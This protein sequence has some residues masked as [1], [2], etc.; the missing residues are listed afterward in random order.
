VT[1]TDDTTPGDG[2]PDDD[3]EGGGGEFRVRPARPADTERMAAAHAAATV[4]LG[5]AAY[6]DRQ[7]RAWARG[8]YEYGLDDPGERVVVAV[9]RAGEDDPYDE[10]LG[11]GAVGFDGGDYLASDVDGDLRAVYVHPA[12][13]RQGV[14][15]ALADEIERA[16][17]ERG[18]ASLGLW[19]SRNAVGFYEAR[20]YE[21][22]E[23]HDHEF[24]DDVTATVVEMRRDLDEA[25]P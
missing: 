10:V 14:G 15:T 5:R 9:R 2:D 3:T 12:F 4:A 11:F 16:A 22:V 13:A 23:E 7:V 19:A 8:R 20:G 25:T 24:A 1:V 18:L 6:D 21:R 17:R